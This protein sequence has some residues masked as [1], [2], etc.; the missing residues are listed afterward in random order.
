MAPFFAHARGV[1]NNG[2]AKL[3]RTLEDIHEAAAMSYTLKV[4]AKHIYFGVLDCV[5]HQI[6]YAKHDGV[7]H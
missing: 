6:L 5:L 3:T 7:A 2:L 1:D 4:K